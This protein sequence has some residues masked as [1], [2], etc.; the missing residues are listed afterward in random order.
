MALTLTQLLAAPSVD[1]LRNMAIQSFQ[2]LGIIVESGLGGGAS[3]L[4]TGSLTLSGTPIAQFTK[5]IVNIVGSGEL[6]T[7]SFQYSLD[8]GVTYSTTF[9]IPLGGTAFLPA[10]GVTITF[11][12]GLS[13]AGTSFVVG[14]MFTFAVNTP[15]LQVTS[16]P[17][18]GGLR[19]LMEFQAQA[20]AKLAG[21]VAALAAG[22]Y[23]SLATGAWC[24]LIGVGFYGLSRLGTGALAGVTTGVVLL[25]DNAGAG[26]FTI[27]ANV[28]GFT[29]TNGLIYF[30]SSG[31]TLP[32]S[33]TLQLNVVAQ[34][35]GSKYNVANGTILT[36]SSGILPGVTV[37][38][39]DPGT[40]SWITT[41]G[42]DAESDSA[43]MLRC[44]QRWSALGTG[45]PASAYQLWTTLAEAATNHPTTVTKSLVQ[46]DSV[47]P[48]QIDIYIAGS[49][50]AV[51]PQ[52]VTD[53]TNYILPRQALTANVIVQS[54]ANRVITL[55][56]TV[57]FLLARTT[58]A[59]AQAA[60][61]TA[62]SAYIAALGIGN[63]LANTPTVYFSE[64]QAA[65]GSVLGGPGVSIRNVAGLNINGA[66]ADVA[67]TLGQ[68]ATLTNS[69]TFVGV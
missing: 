66:T 51:N 63:G 52:A 19:L 13:G 47:V 10:P 22:G 61:Q 59:L 31:G 26:P 38:N 39:P 68:V 65:I 4:G 67:L 18:S 62:S 48:G 8:G 20:L 2:G 56:G 5:I 57:N 12:P 49:S 58:V 35:P 32:R 55:T 24:D 3:P 33:G 60:I 6:G 50:G 40:G 17:A 15:S 23:T 44:Q 28:M 42:T 14:D 29:S 64:I 16:W 34:A 41:Q 53:V 21:Q 43:Y 7:A 46:V 36:I 54:A 25:V 1:N 69:L 30:N 11:V 9:V 27:A 37:S 45:S